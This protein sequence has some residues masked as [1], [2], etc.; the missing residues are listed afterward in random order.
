MGMA[1]LTEWALYLSV[2]YAVQQCIYGQ[3][4]PLS[5]MF[6]VLTT[7]ICV[8]SFLVFFS[9]IPKYDQKS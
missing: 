2:F 5:K 7:L 9:R 4:R 6:Q 3:F 1:Q 8:V